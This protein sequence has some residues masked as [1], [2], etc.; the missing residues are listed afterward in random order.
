MS[1]FWLLAAVF[2]ITL[3]LVLFLWVRSA[4]E[5]HRLGRGRVWMLI[6][7]VPALLF[8]PITLDLF[9]ARALSEVVVPDRKGHTTDIAGLWGD[10]QRSELERSLSD[11]ESTSGFR[12]DVLTA[13]GTT[14]QAFAYQVRKFAQRHSVDAL[15]GV[16]VEDGRA[17]AYVAL[18]G[19][20]GGAEESAKLRRRLLSPLSGKD[21]A[22]AG[23]ALSSL[24]PALCNAVE[25]ARENELSSW[26]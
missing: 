1:L 12:V 19:D 16:L 17:D 22:D 26:W 21:A 23:N 25:R 18:D 13:K 5:V 10:G 7:G 9:H 20:L 24:G 6:P 11:C 14:V 8:V 2:T 4:L 15:I 3:S